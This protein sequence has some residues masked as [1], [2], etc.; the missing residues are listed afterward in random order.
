MIDPMILIALAFAGAWATALCA[1]DDELEHD[2]PRGPGDSKGDEAGPKDPKPARG[3]PSKNAPPF[4]FEGQS[5][6]GTREPYL[7]PTI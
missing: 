3:T 1:V 2:E 5:G 6:A 4:P 7:R